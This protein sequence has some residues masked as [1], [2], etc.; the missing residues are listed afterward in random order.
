[1]FRRKPE[2]VKSGMTYLCNMSFLNLFAHIR[3]EQI[4]LVLFHHEPDD[5]NLGN[6]TNI[7]W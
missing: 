2:H 3:R 5:R 6:E 1:M 4:F 7:V